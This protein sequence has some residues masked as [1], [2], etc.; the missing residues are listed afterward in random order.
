MIFQVIILFSADCSGGREWYDKLTDWFY[1]N[2][3]ASIIRAYKTVNNFV[4][5][6]G[7]VNE[8]KTVLVINTN[9]ESEFLI[10]RLLSCFQPD[11]YIEN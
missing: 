9:G 10:D 8:E 5:A 11:R 7:N 1:N 2:I 4:R 3:L 6:P